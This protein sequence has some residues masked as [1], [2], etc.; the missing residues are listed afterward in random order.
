MSTY[1]EPKSSGPTGLGKKTRFCLVRHGSTAWNRERRMQGEKDLP[2]NE[3]GRQQAA[4]TAHRLKNG[5]WEIVVASDL[6]RARETAEIIGRELGLP[7]LLFPGLRERKM[8]P[9][10]GLTADE[11]KEKFP[12]WYQKKDLDLPGVERRRELKERAKAS[13]ETLAEIF[14]GRRVVVVAHGMFFGAFFASCLGGDRQVLGNGEAVEVI[15]E[16]GVW[17]ESGEGQDVSGL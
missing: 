4:E 6:L 12:E 13:L 14:N 8:G 15:W 1:E 2:L 11:I 7:V 16:N 3:E 10:E 5:G 9:L 17:K